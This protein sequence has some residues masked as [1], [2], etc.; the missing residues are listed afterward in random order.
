MKYCFV[1]Y[2][3]FCFIVDD[4]S[5]Q[6]MKIRKKTGEKFDISRQKVK[7]L[8]IPLI[9]V[10]GR[11]A[12]LTVVQLTHRRPLLNGLAGHRALSQNIFLEKCGRKRC[13]SNRDGRS[14]ERVA[15]QRRFRNLVGLHKER[16]EVIVSDKWETSS[17]F[18]A[19][20]HCRN[21]GE[22]QKHLRNVEGERNWLVSLWSKVPRV[23]RKKTGVRAESKLLEA[24][25]DVST[26]SD[27]FG[28]V[29][30]L[31]CWCCSAGV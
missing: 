21:Q 1:L 22:H 5:S 29:L 12:D 3:L 18:P 13:T 11:T 2:L 6:F 15:K 17:A 4:Y 16:T 24:Q 20:S 14:L 9:A 10:M 31:W 23:W 26:V 19:S 25:R 8:D 7:I 30:G 28:E 27:G